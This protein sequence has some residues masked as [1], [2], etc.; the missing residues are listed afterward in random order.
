MI[1]S[2]KLLIPNPSPFKLIRIGGNGDGAYLLPDDLDGIDACFSPGVNNFKNF[3]DTLT[4]EYGIKSHM[5]DFSSE[6]SQFRTPL[7]NGMQTFK[8]KWLDVDGG[9]DS[10]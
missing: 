3:E 6:P 9:R 1:N 10:I 7:I 2:L 4:K 5:C 8:K